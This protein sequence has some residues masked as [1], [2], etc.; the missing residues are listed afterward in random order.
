MQSSS[1]HTP[2]SI[3]WM[4]CKNL[5]PAIQRDPQITSLHDGAELF[6][7]QGSAMN[8]VAVKE[9]NL[10]NHTIVILSRMGFPYNRNLGCL[11]SFDGRNR[12]ILDN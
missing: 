10:D 2:F 5:C 8:R 1:V 7:F 6:Q 9:L 11:V 3:S 12:A 4:F